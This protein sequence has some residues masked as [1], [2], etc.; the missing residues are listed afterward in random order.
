ME[1]LVKI[2]STIGFPIAVSIYLLYERARF[3]EKIIRTQTDI[4][5]TLQLIAERLK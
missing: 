5:M 3:N 2:I 1:E 4:S